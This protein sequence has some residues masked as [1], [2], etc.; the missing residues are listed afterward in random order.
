MHR[1]QTSWRS[2]RLIGSS[3]PLKLLGFGESIA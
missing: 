1:E 3:M 2:V